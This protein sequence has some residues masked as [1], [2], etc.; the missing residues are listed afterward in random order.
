MGI[1][2]KEALSNWAKNYEKYWNAGDRKG[3]IDNYRTVFRGDSV[4]MLDPVSTPEKFGFKHCCEDSYDLFQPNVKFHVPPESMF[5]LGNEVAWVMNNHITNDGKEFM[6]P[7]IESF[8]FEADGSLII[9]TWYRIPQHTDDTMGEMFK[10][11]LPNNDGK[12]GIT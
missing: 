12:T 7:S 4:R 8:R 6:E 1:P 9:R 2:T 5:I 3:W 10:T 11:Y